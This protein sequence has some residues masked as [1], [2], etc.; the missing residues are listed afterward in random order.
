MDFFL[1]LLFVAGVAII[2]LILPIV[3]LATASG[4]KRRV[5]LLESSLHA[6]A[7]RIA[8]APAAEPRAAAPALEPVAAV[9]TTE[10]VMAP[11]AAASPPTAP[12]PLPAAAYGVAPSAHVDLERLIGGTWLSWIGIAALLVATAFFLAYAFENNWIGPT[13]RIAIGFV[14]GAALMAYSQVLF[15]KSFVYFSEGIAGLGAGVLFLS[16]WAAW[17]SYHLIPSAGAFAGMVL[18][19]AALLGFS[20]ARDSQRVAIIALVGGFVTPILLNTGEDAEVQLFTYLAVLNAGLL[21]VAYVRDWRT[22]PVAFIFTELYFW[23]WF[24]THYDASRLGVTLSFATLFFAEFGAIATLRAVRDGVLHSEQAAM[25]LLNAVWYTVALHFM[26]YQNNRWMLS[27]AVVALAIV[28]LLVARN[29]PTTAQAGKLVRTIFAGLALS[30]VTLAIPIRLQGQ[31]LTIGWSVEG[32]V[33]VWT[34]LQTQTRW[35][36]MA[37]VGLFALVVLQMVLNPIPDGQLIFNQRFST[38]AVVIACF[39]VAAWLA[40][41][42]RSELV[43]DEVTIF[44][45]VEVAI[46][47]LALW[48]LSAEVAGTPFTGERQALLLTLVW[49]LYAAALLV[50]GIRASSALLRWQGLVLLGVSVA[51]VFLYD[52]ATLALGLRILSF[53]VL[54]IVLL[55]ISFLYQK[56]LE[57]E[58]M[59][60]ER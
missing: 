59:K 26:L 58:R 30:F 41:S 53:M 5:D 8:A 49:T 60:E 48:A 22:L 31:W 38:F 23:A 43:G 40:V 35:L 19:T 11:S 7:Y 14:A 1:P 28:H 27:G 42:R 10:P 17:S 24:G 51:K 54:G 2:I 12:A 36:R 45:A 18:V 55:G 50:I 13:G 33:L 37:G 57:P 9:A 15:K 21:V 29:V 52:L 4:L 46:N 25:V 47:V 34:G 16:L 6:L 56:R 39:G 44:R 32:S 20:V 3:A